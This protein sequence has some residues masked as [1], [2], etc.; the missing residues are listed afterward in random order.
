MKRYRLVFILFLALTLMACNL[1]SNLPGNRGDTESEVEETAEIDQNVQA[2]EPVEGLKPSEVETPE[3]EVETVNNSVPSDSASMGKESACDH[4]Y[5]PM[6]EGA[7]WVYYEPEEDYY[8]FWEVVSVEG[9]SQ[10]ATA[11]MTSHIGQFSELTEEL[12]QTAIKIEYNWVCTAAEGIV[13][14]DLAVL[15]IP[16]IEDQEFEMTMTFVDGEGVMLPAADLLEPGYSWEM[17]VQMNFS[18]PAMMNAE[19]TMTFVDYYTVVTKDPVEFNGQTFEGIQYEREF[20]SEMEL[21]LGG[22]PVSLPFIDLDFQTKTILAKGIGYI[23]L[24][25]DS[26]FGA[27]GLQL[28][29]Y[30]IP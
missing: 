23:K 18:M 11:L 15:E 7:S 14:F 20:D 27:T 19:G 22:A 3:P 5:F 16:N 29:R 24:D 8:H 12:K 21:T 9:D 30:N 25:S 1:T 13:S 2:D 26:D 10:N 28:I 6:R 17:S 4:P